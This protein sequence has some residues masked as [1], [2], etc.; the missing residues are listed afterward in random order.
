MSNEKTTVA[1]DLLSEFNKVDGFNPEM[2]ARDIKDDDNEIPRKYLDVVWRKL[3]FRLK[4]PNGKISKRIIHFTEKSAAVEARVY[5][6]KNDA[7][8]NYVSSG[9]A[10]RESD[11][12][13]VKFGNRYLESTE[14]IAIGRALADAGFGLQFCCDPS[15]N[16]KEDGFA[17]APINIS[18]GNQ[19]DNT[20]SAAPVI[21]PV[22]ANTATAEDKKE[23]K[24]PAAT[25]GKNGDKAENG[26]GDATNTGTAAKTVISTPAAAPKLPGTGLLVNTG[27]NKLVKTPTANP[28][29]SV[30]TDKPAEKTGENTGN[31]ENAIIK[32][33]PAASAD[34]Q[35]NTGET[36]EKKY[37]NTMEVSE[38]MELM[39]FNE[40]ASYVVD[41]G[42]YLGK[43]MCEVVG[44]TAEET[45]KKLSWYYTNY[46]GPN[47]CLRAAAK[48]MAEYF[49]GMDKKAKSGTENGNKA[50]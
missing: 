25:E 29:S 44:K 9:F 35:D 26:S 18:Q 7:E 27:A 5:L 41:T 22:N 24:T 3:W 20:K 23:V 47:N 33:I 37:D 13:N 14:T 45:I 31:L 17:D 38:I 21:P 40:A 1:N 10:H 36:Q 8:E 46:G 19:P 30:K 48:I 39:T 42:G 6:D 11:P 28:T 49:E 15:G 43:E 12:Q 16:D 34:N 2:Y 32:D 4:Y 50:A